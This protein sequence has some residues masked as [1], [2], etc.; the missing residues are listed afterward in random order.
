MVGSAHA[1]SLLV[2]FTAGLNTGDFS[3]PDNINPFV[4]GNALNSFAQTQPDVLRVDGQFY[5]PNYTG[6]GTYSASFNTSTGNRI[7]LHSPLIE[8]IEAQTWRA[9]GASNFGTVNG[10]G[11]PISQRKKFL[12]PDDTPNGTMSVTISAGAI[13]GLSYLY[14]YAANSGLPFAGDSGNPTLNGVTF[15]LIGIS[16]GSDDFGASQTIGLGSIDALASAYGLNTALDLGSFPTGL[17]SGTVTGLTRGILINEL[18]S[19]AE[20]GNSGGN[21]TSN[22]R[23]INSGGTDDP[24]A[25]ALPNPFT[26]ESGD[27]TIFNSTRDLDVNIAAVPEPSSALLLSLSLLAGLGRRKRV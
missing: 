25:T 4:P 27:L 13:T 5:V 6:D 8:R 11:D 14:D 7:L 12:L 3:G 1:S 24:G 15:N 9:E 23:F 2:N 22:G 16:G 26:G 20:P 18:T 21:I 10:A 19:T 17:L